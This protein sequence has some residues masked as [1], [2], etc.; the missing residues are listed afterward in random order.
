MAASAGATS[1][2]NAFALALET[3]S[4]SGKSNVLL[5]GLNTLNSNIFFEANIG[6]AS[7]TV[8]AGNGGTNTFGAVTGP[9]ASFTLDFYANFDVIYAIQDGIITARF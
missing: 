5:S 7:A 9:T 2:K 4:F 6:Y 1:Y 8:L 3:E